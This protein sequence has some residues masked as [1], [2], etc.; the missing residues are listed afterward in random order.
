MI[1]HLRA[2][3]RLLTT[4]GLLAASA[5]VAT[6]STAAQAADIKERNIKLALVVDR[7]TAQY[8]G[9]EKFAEQV[10]ARSGGLLKVRIFGGGTLGGDLPVLSSL[11]GGTIEMTLLN[12][13]LL[14]G[15]VKEFAVFD[16]PFLFANEKE[17]DAVVDG[18]VGR[19]LLDLL[20][21]KGLV[22]LAY[23]EL[24]FRNMHN[25]KRAITRWEDLAGLKMRVIQTPI[26]LDLLNTL[27]AN[28]VPLPFP[29][30]YTALEQKAMDGATNPP[31][32]MKVQKFD[33][34]QKFYSVT[35]HMYNP[36]T[37]LMS[38]KTW[39][40]LSADEQK[41]LVDAAR[42]AGLYERKVSRQKNA[43][44]LAELRKTLQVNEVSPAELAR[45]RDKARPVNEKYAKQVGETL[46]KEVY[47]EIDK[48]RAARP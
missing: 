31:I 26:Y 21:A 38:G 29:E 13:S 11:Q 42:E 16:F 35:H 41:I 36:Q 7:G 15:N 14:Q 23:W 30:L 46:V 24:G 34:V 5:T 27:G 19:K 39:A 17:A 33:E 37:L 40:A 47:A 6:L 2:T 48:V 45:M 20:P 4:C 1:R 25:S 18:P 28:A 32:T 22:G 43:E 3:L 8:D 12:A 9:A 10:K 44:A